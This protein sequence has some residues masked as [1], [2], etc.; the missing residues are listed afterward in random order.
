M[1]SDEVNRIRLPPLAGE[2]MFK[3]TD[4]EAMEI[5]DS[6]GNPTLKTVV[7]TKGGCGFFCVPSGAS[8][9]K[10]EALELR[11][12]GKRFLGKGVLQAVHNVNAKLKKLVAERDL[13]IEVMKEVAAKKW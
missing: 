10:T 5:L 11:D 1:R 2:A 13:E 7:R 3:I 4:V 6:R 12:G 8:K 9:G